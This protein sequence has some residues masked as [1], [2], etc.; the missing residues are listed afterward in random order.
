MKNF[1]LTVTLNPAVDEI[2]KVKK[3]RTAPGWI[4]GEQRSCAGGK[5]I[6][7]ARALT[8]LGTPVVA[9]GLLGGITGQFIVEELRREKIKND[10]V[11]EFF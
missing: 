6:N 9:T 8:R 10:F 11:Q 4:L 7:V 1:V 3:H 2:F 5:G